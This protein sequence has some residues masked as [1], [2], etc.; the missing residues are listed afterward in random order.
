MTIIHEFSGR[1][2]MKYV[3]RRLRYNCARTY[4]RDYLKEEDT[5]IDDSKMQSIKDDSKKEEDCMKSSNNEDNIKESVKINSK[6][7]YLNNYKRN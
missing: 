4:K 7:R 3:T 6:I 2:Q 1:E 5:K